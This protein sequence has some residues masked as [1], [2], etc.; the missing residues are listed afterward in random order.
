[1][2]RKKNGKVMGSKTDCQHCGKSF[3]VPGNYAHE[4]VC[5]KNPNPQ[6]QLSEPRDKPCRYCH[7]PFKAKGI[8]SH[9]KACSQRLRTANTLHQRQAPATVA[10]IKRR[11]A[12]VGHAKRKPAVIATSQLPNRDLIRYALD[13]VRADLAAIT[14]MIGNDEAK[15]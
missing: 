3:I 6:Q 11:P 10:R 2:P 5:K 1:M 13:R 4:R 8:G 15:P 14:E 12:T 7:L 9:E